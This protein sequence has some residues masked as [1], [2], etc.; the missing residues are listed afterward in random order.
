M[1]RRNAAAN[2]EQAGN[3]R[4]ADERST[5]YKIQFDFSE[6]AKQRLEE[7][8]KKTDVDMSPLA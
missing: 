3:E 4:A 7:L 6:A 2:R 5:T 8:V 1:P